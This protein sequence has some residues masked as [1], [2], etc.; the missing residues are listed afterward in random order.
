MMKSHVLELHPAQ[1]MKHP[2]VQ[3]VHAMYTPPS[4]VI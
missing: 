1:D 4:L 2:C 3:R